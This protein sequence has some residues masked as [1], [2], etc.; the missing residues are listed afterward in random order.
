M[1]PVLSLVLCSRNDAYMGDSRWR[2]ETT[3]NFTA[4]RVREARRLTDVEIIVADWGSEVPLQQVI[5]LTADAAAMT[6]IVHVPPAVAVRL[7]GDSAFPEVLALNAA[8]RRASG[9]FIGRID[10]DTLVGGRFIEYFFRVL[11]GG[12]AW[13]AS[14][15]RSVW[16]ANRRSIPFRLAEENA[17]PRD[18]HAGGARAGPMLADLA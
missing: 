18:R 4:A 6:R 13:P 2:F 9:T 15:D 12:V 14:L 8:I 1:A 11:E 17:A 16:Y 10:Q 7:Q 3:I 5:R